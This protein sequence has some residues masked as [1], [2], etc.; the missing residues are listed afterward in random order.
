ILL[1]L[2]AFVASVRMIADSIAPDNF[3]VK[4]LG[5]SFAPALVC[6]AVGQMALFVLL[7]LALFLRF[8]KS[9]PVCAGAALWLCLLKP[10]LFLPLGLVLCAWIWTRRQ[11]QV[12]LGTAV[13]IGISAALISMLDPH[14][15]IQYRGMMQLMRYV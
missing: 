11:F 3:A 2:G 4:V 5:Y 10:Q 12:L 13:A 14:C 8:H 6:I 9:H 1:L 7:G 15:W